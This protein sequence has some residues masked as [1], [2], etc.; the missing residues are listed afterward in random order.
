L[1]RLELM[2]AFGAGIFIGRHSEYCKEVRELHLIGNQFER[3]S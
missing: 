1:E 2:A 3:K